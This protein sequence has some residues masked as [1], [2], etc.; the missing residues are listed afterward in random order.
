AGLEGGDRTLAERELTVRPGEVLSLDDVDD[1]ATAI[2]QALVRNGYLDATVDPETG[3]NRARSIAD[4]TFHVTPGA[5][6]KIAQIVIE[7]DVRPFDVRTLA[8]QMRRR[9]GSAF[10]IREARED[11]ERMK[12]FLLRRDHRRADVDF[13]DYIYDRATHGVTLRYR[14][15]AGPKVR[16]EVAGVPRRAVR[17]LL[18]FRARNAEYSE[19]AIERAADQ[20]VRAYQLRGHYHASV[21][22]ESR[23]QNGEWVTI[24]HVNPG[25]R[26]RLADVTFSGN[27]KLPDKE[28]DD[29]VET[30]ARG[31]F[32]R[33]IATL[34]RRPTGVTGEQLSDDRDA[35]ESYYRLQGFSEATVTTPNV[36]TN[37]AAATMTVEFPVTEGP[38]TIVADVHIEGNEKFST[39]RLPEL[40]LEAGDPLNPQLHHENIVALQTFYADRGH[41]E[42]QVTDRVETSA[43][44]TSAKVAYVITEGPRVNVD[45]VIVRGNTYTDDEVALRR[46]NLDPGDPFSYTSILEAQRELYRLGIFQRV[47]I[48]PEQTGTTVGDR[49]VVI[50]V[51][52]GRNLTLTGAIGL[53]AE[54]GQQEGRGYDLQPRLALAAAHRNLFGTG[55]YFGI[56]AVG[57]TDEQEVFLTYREPFISRFDVPLQVQVYQSD[58]NTRPGAH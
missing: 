23:V 9:T 10:R 25:V 31:G 45:E 50:E 47:E 33:M 6:A 4:V 35:L 27:I 37:D 18:P 22:T 14:A 19:D 46:S 21:D 3:F 28:L 49:D 52:E 57:G 42:V 32:R 5:Q 41:T 36:V 58:D 43:D 24:F 13:I 16:V 15:N 38:Q 1:S 12:N 55:R 34:F 11:A 44:K 48:Q 51:E 26:Y 20:I 29:V 54:R 40:Q 53:R 2:Q 8:Q 7:G 39:E 17:R 56:E 30:S